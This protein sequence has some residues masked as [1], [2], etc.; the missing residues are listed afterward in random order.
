MQLVINKKEKRISDIIQFLSEIEK[1]EM[2]EKIKV[3]EHRDEIDEIAEKLNNI[4]F[5]HKNIKWG[6]PYVEKRLTEIVEVIMGISSLDFS[7][8]AHVSSDFN[9][10]DAISEGLN[11]LGEELL[12]STV[13][14]NYLNNILQSMSDMLFVLD[15]N[16]EI[17]TVNDAT[18]EI[19]GY[20]DYEI[21]GKNIN[22]ILEKN[23]K[24][25][26]DFFENIDLSLTKK[27]ETNLIGKNGD[28]HS[29]IF[30]YS[31][32]IE[33][34]NSFKGI[35]C[36]A[37][38]ITERKK[39]EKELRNREQKIRKSLEEKNVLLK[40]INHRVK[41]N[42]QVVM[43]L[44]YLQGQ[45]ID[46]ANIKQTLKESQERIKSMALVHEQLYKSKD[47]SKISMKTYF[48]KL[49]QQLY[50]S[51]GFSKN[52]LNIILKIKNI[53]LGITMAVPCGL[54]VNELI[55]NS[56]KHAF[57]PMAGNEGG[58]KK[59]IFISFAKKNEKY[60]LII[61]DNGKGFPENYKIGK[62]DSLGMVL[63][64]TLTRQL[65]GEL[66]LENRN[67]AYSRITF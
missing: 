38:D 65:E 11:I 67:G 33:K 9:T 56:L 30:S 63:V 23:N 10:F 31:L 22:N 8:K 52:E 53:F 34:D 57:E 4:V 42:L 62:T 36:I 37:S 29:V 15:K 47:L 35:V 41:N 32:M 3:S 28:K 2:P 54:I 16:G 21:L 7:K 27:I 26:K 60:E 43:S 6:N 51:Y 5:K 1:E 61:R 44:L 13:S 25:L 18:V 46:D 40:E 66:S 20:D 49:V 48:D 17:Q 50:Q 59:E 39:I 24:K 64:E 55:S 19:L 45:K 14:R 58:A 12:A